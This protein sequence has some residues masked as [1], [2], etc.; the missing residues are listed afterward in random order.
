MASSVQGPLTVLEEH[1]AKYPSI[2]NEVSTVTNLYKQKLWHDIADPLVAY[3]KNK[4][5]DSASEN[6]DLITLY[7]SMVKLLHNKMNPMKY[8]IVTVSASRQFADFD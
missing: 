3:F 6:T 2:S 4:V 8:A 7:D 5:F 1:A